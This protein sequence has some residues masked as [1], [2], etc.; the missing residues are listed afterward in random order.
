MLVTAETGMAMDRSPE[1]VTSIERMAETS[2]LRLLAGSVAGAS[3]LPNQPHRSRS[4]PTYLTAEAA[5]MGPRAVMTRCLSATCSASTS[6]RSG[7]LK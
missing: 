2:M 3:P 1:T 7:S 6:K 4:Q 5:T